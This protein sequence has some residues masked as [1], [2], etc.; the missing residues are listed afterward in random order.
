MQEREREIA[1]PIEFLSDKS[2]NFENPKLVTIGGY[3]L[4]A[5]TPLARYTRDCD[6]VLRKENEWKLDRIKKLM[7]KHMS[8]VSLEKHK[9]YGF[10]RCVKPVRV[11]GRL[12]KVSLD[13]MEG[14]VVGRSEK[15]QVVIDEGFTND[16]KK[17]KIEIAGTKFEIYIPSYRDYFILKIVSGRASDTRDIAT[18]VWQKGI[19]DQIRNRAKQ[20]VPFPEIFDENLR[21]AIADISDRRFVDSWRGT[22]ISKDFSED[23]KE[24]VLQKLGELLR[25]FMNLQT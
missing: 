18:L 3:A 12:V 19:P 8:I 16:S 15:E 17:Q 22:F 20:I 21:K 14:K 9:D 25:E 7:S 24:K 11:G 4:R 2:Q 10:M 23:D 6:F 13:F 1:E 5:F